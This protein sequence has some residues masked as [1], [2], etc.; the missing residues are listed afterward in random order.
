MLLAIGIGVLWI[1]LPGFFESQYHKADNH[2]DD[3]NDEGGYPP[4]H[5]FI[6]NRSQAC[7]ANTQTDSSNVY[8]IGSGPSSLREIIVNQAN[9]SRRVHTAYE[10]EAYSYQ[11]D[12]PIAICQ[13]HQNL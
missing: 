10:G 4:P 8:R 6:N 2:S 12:G 9:A 3:S 5:L 1:F 13:M 11:E 7:K